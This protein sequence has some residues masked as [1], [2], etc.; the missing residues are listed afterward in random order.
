MKKDMFNGNIK[1]HCINYVKFSLIFVAI[2]WL[3]FFIFFFLIA[4]SYEKQEY[5]ARISLFIFSGICFLNIFLYPGISIYAIRKYPKHPKLAK[6]M[7][8]PSVF[9]DIDN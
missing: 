9:Q 4:L 8:R 7:L 1:K 3:V 5:A 2:L 6:S